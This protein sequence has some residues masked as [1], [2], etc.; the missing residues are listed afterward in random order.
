VITSTFA[1]ATWH[2]SHGTCH[3]PPATGLGPFTAVRPLSCLLQAE[4]Q[5]RA[6]Y[7]PELAREAEPVQPESRVMAAR[8]HHPQERRPPCDEEF[9][10]PQRV[11]SPELVQVVD[12]QDDRPLQ[13]AQPGCQPP[14]DRLSL[15]RR[16]RPKVVHERVRADR[17]ADLADH[18]EPEVLRVLLLALDRHPGDPVPHAGVLNP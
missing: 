10:L 2:L 4:A 11:G 3:P 16:G 6:A 18:R 12:H 1:D 14:D 7:L 8:Q 17:G 15:E 5:I 9:E 13:R